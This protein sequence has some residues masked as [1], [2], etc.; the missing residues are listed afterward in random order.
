MAKAGLVGVEKDLAEAGLVA[1]LVDFTDFFLCNIYNM[2]ETED[3]EIPVEPELPKGVNAKPKKVMSELQLEKLKIAREKAA[4]VK[5]AARAEKDKLE[6]E[7][8][9]KEKAKRLAKLEDKVKKSHIDL[10]EK[11]QPKQESLEEQVEIIRKPKKP[12]KK[13]VVMH[14]SGSDSDSETQVIYIPRRSNKSSK[15]KDA[16]PPEQ[17]PSQPL[18]FGS[19]PRYQ[20]HN[21]NH[22]RS[23][24]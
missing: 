18:A 6:A 22:N 24:Y 4:Q 15:P 16:P 17:T 2:S 13:V 1:E 23:F 12:K 3:L 9:E 20:L 11:P 19:M 7:L 5:K 8:R 10:D 14:D 21:F